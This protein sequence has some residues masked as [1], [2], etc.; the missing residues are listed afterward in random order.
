M[1]IASACPKIP[2][3]PNT[4]FEFADGK[5]A[6]RVP[7]HR[8]ETFANS[9]TRATQLELRARAGSSLPLATYG[10]VLHLDLPWPSFL[11]GH[12]CLRLA[13]AHGCAAVHAGL[14]AFQSVRWHSR[15]QYRT[16]SHT[17]SSSRLPG[18]VALYTWTSGMG[19]RPSGVSRQFP[20]VAL[21]GPVR[22]AGLPP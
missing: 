7:K 10:R 17:L 5:G 8:M 16:A 15:E 18:T 12:S 3:T 4:C 14:C 9:H 19:W 1:V 6:V 20:S 22:C 11:K 13:Y 21:T 2:G